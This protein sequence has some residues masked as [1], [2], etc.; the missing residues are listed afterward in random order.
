MSNSSANNIT[1]YDLTHPLNSAT[2]AWPEDPHYKARK[3]TNIKEHG[4]EMH[5]ISMSTHTATHI[6]APSHFIHGG[7]TID[8]VPLSTLVGPA[9]F[10]DL[11][12]RELR[13]NQEITWDDIKSYEADL[14]PGVI[15]V[16][17]T[18]WYEKWGEDAYYEHPFMA[19]EVA[20]KFID[21]GIKVVG[22]DT[23]NPDETP[24][25]GDTKGGY[26][27]HKTLLGADGIII[28]N[29]T[30]T[31]PLIG[32]SNVQISLVPLKLEGID[33]SPIRAIAW[34]PSDPPQNEARDSKCGIM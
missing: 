15:V 5:E 8:Q 32:R 20:K 10:I 2:L 4:Y 24:S 7:R 17:C 22:V 29:L 28:E 25:K 9:V 11:T 6:D 27:F 1:Y 14:K 33:G 18:G 23:L 26:G 21:F 12:K 31:K 16:V 30:N 34:H 19:K 3:Y 13:E